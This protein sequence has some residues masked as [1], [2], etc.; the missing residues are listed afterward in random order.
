MGERATFTSTH[1]ADRLGDHRDR[2]PAADPSSAC[3][4]AH[5]PQGFRTTRGAAAA[6]PRPLEDVASMEQES[7]MT[8]LE[9]VELAVRR[10]RG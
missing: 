4:T 3:P 7:G 9:A 10:L 5:R 8:V 2:V 1:P 6:S